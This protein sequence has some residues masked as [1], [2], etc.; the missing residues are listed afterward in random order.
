MPQTQEHPL[1]IESNTTIMIY[2]LVYMYSERGVAML[3]S[4]VLE[5]KQ[6]RQHENEM[7]LLFVCRQKKGEKQ[8]KEEIETNTRETSKEVTSLVERLIHFRWMFRRT[9]NG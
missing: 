1:V 3:L 9:K 8:K 2:D 6:D 7:L 4:K 5:K